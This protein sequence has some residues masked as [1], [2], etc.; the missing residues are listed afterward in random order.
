[1]EG[2]AAGVIRAAAGRVRP[3]QPLI[4]IN[5]TIFLSDKG[6][7]NGCEFRKHSPPVL[8]TSGAAA[9]PAKSRGALGSHAAVPRPGPSLTESG[10]MQPMDL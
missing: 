5:Q 9:L 4:P 3:L 7:D 8:Q 6:R 1:M 10:G 2:S